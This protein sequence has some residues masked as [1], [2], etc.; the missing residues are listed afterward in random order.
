MKQSIR[1]VSDLVKRCALTYVAGGL[2]II[3]A[4]IHFP[5]SHDDSVW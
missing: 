5:D 3:G 2:Q 4:R 1:E